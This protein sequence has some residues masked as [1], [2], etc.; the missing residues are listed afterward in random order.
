[1]RDCRS[2]E[3]TA[4]GFRQDPNQRTSNVRHLVQGFEMQFEKRRFGGEHSTKSRAMIA[5]AQLT[6]PWRLLRHFAEM[7]MDARHD[8]DFSIIFNNIY[9]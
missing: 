9:K 6:P 5:W 7:T 3:G 1:M 8:D 2:A 4:T